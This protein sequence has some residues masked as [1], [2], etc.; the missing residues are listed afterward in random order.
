MEKKV[1]SRLPIN[2]VPMKPRVLVSWNDLRV[3]T[4]WMKNNKQ[5][6]SIQQTFTHMEWK[7]SHLQ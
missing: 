2:F 4:T 5:L 6:I 7:I 3:M 1:Q